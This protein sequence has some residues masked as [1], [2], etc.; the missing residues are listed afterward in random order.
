MA[1]EER[2]R[3]SRELTRVGDA[4]GRATAVMGAAIVYFGTWGLNAILGLFPPPLGLDLTHPQ[5]IIGAVALV[6][7]LF[8]GRWLVRNLSTRRLV[9]VASWSASLFGVVAVGFAALLMNLAPSSEAVAVV[10]FGM[11]LSW[12]LATVWVTLLTRRAR[13]L[14]AAV[15]EAG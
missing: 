5:F 2:D 10:V 15:A 6:A 13:R 7:S 12:L 4:L 14:L 3:S 9:T 8:A 11:G 1:R